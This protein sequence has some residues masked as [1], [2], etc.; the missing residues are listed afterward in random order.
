MTISLIDTVRD[1]LTSG[2]IVNGAASALGVSPSTATR[3][4][5]GAGSAVL[6]G[7][8][9]KARDPL[10]LGEFFNMAQDPALASP[11][12]DDPGRLLSADPEATRARD[13]GSRLMAGLFGG[14]TDDVVNSLGRHAG[15]NTT[16]AASMM[17]MAA[18][19]ILRAFGGLIRGGGLT[20][21]SLGQMLLSNQSEIMNAVCG[22]VPMAIP[23]ATHTPAHSWSR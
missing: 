23:V 12:L 1:A 14:R 10:A 2:G 3:A 6:G 22:T 13:L 21:G 8:A 15:L 16:T 5:S 20:V 19:L 17:T 7:L 11:T 18:P 9:N 4:L